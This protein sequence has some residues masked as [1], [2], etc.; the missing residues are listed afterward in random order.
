MFFWPQEDGSVLWTG[1]FNQEE[2]D[3]YHAERGTAPA[4]FTGTVT[5][6]SGLTLGGV[7]ASDLDF[8][9]D[10]AESYE[11]WTVEE[12]KA[13]IRARNEGR[14]DDAHLSLTGNKADLIS[15]L[16]AD[17]EDGA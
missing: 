7:D 8:G 15:A 1:S 3:A 16:E 13:E 9:T 11:S 14:E 12:L 6:G 5:T 17:D 2:W 10:E 4:G